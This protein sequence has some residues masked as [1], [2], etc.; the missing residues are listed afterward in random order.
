MAAVVTLSC[1]QPL[2]TLLA[3][4]PASVDPMDAWVEVT[5]VDEQG[6]VYKPE[7]SYPPG[8]SEVQ[9][10]LLGVGELPETLTLYAGYLWEGAGNEAFDIQSVIALHP[11]P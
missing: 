3:P 1:E 2:E 10:T 7:T 4:P 11:A 6:R 9:F 5:A 8:E